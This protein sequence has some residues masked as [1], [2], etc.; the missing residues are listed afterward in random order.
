MPACCYPNR[1]EVE[2]LFG[3][4]SINRATGHQADINSIG[5]V[6]IKF[7]LYCDEILK[8]WVTRS[9]QR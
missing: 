1:L 9:E 6:L 3:S 2:N 7:A 8:M 5:W 4:R